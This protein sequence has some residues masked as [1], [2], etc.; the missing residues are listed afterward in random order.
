MKRRDAINTAGTAAGL[1]GASTPAFGSGKPQEPKLRV[2]ASRFETHFEAGAPTFG[3]SGET[4]SNA[5]GPLKT[6][7]MLIEDGDKRLCL[8]TSDLR[9]EILNLNRFLREEAAKVLGLD[10]SEV[11]FFA[12]H[13]HSVSPL[14]E[15]EVRSWKWYQKSLDE[16]PEVKLLPVGKRFLASLQQHLSSLPNKLEPVTVAWAQGS[17]GRITYN[18]KGRRADGSTY[19]MREEDRELLGEDYSGDIDKE[20]P[21]VVF[22]NEKEKPIAALLQFTGHPVTSFHPEDLTIHGD[23]P[24]VAADVLGQALGDGGEP[25]PVAFLQGCGGDSS[26]KEMFVGGVSRAREFGEM[27]GQS[28]VDAL[29]DLKPSRLA[30]MDYV[31]QTVGIPLAPLPAK[32]IILNEIEE[33]KDFMRRANAGDEDTLSC[34]GQN[35][36][37]A[38]TPKYRGSLVAMLLEWNEWALS[39]YTQGK[40][41]DVMQSLEVPLYVLRLGDVAVAGMPFEPFLGIGRQIRAQSPFPLSIP[42][43]YVN[44]THGYVTDSGNTGDREYM[45]AFHRYT[46]FRPPFAKPAGDVVADRAAATLR[47]FW[48]RRQT[49]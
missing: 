18:R 2:A 48:E 39:M 15:V 5:A 3:Y 25:V 23:Y 36:P 20:V 47:E 49:T 33:M 9:V 16:L 22:R 34:V 12:S 45:S 30:G 1:A 41:G 7:V 27:L 42:C 46:R 21:V 26:S 4:V 28:A 35:F 29:A 8:V 14:A 44:E 13:D 19:F 31:E 17:E 40:E 24:S 6:T 10:P 43:G 37:R 38:L 11:L 32:E